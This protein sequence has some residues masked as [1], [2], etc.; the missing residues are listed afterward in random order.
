M[1]GIHI[2][3]WTF[4]PGLPFLDSCLN[5][6]KIFSSLIQAV[7]RDMLKSSKAIFC[8][9]VAQIIFPTEP[10]ESIDALMLLHSHVRVFPL[11]MCVM[12][13]QRDALDRLHGSCYKRMNAI[14]NISFCAVCAIN[15]KSFS[16]TKLRMCCFSGELSCIHCPMEGTVVTVNML[17]V[18][19]KISST[20]YYMCPR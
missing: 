10:E 1:E 13:W 9:E 15:G 17:G 14:Q 2:F 3:N 4:F 20:Y 16:S 6:C 5:A 8:K 19:L 18:V 7:H 11:P 12:E